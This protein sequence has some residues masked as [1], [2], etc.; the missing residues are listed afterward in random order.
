MSGLLDWQQPAYRVLGSSVWHCSLA[1]RATVC[2]RRVRDPT[3]CI[4]HAINPVLVSI[5]VTYIVMGH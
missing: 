5:Q 3:H 4:S 1:K 2:D